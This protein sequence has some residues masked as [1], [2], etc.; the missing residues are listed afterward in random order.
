M[1]NQDST[2]PCILLHGYSINSIFKRKQH[3]ISNVF[4]W[5]YFVMYSHNGDGPQEDL[6]R[7]GES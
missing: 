2:L 7:F 4:F 1:H 3:L 6:V 5:V